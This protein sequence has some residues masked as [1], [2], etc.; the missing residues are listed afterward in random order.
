MSFSNNRQKDTKVRQLRS[1]WV[2][3]GAPVGEA[4]IK[5]EDPNWIRSSR[6]AKFFILIDTIS[7]ANMM[8]SR[9]GQRQLCVGAWRR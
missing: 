1:V 4:D 3:I 5:A 8:G 7:A 2:P 6:A 9:G